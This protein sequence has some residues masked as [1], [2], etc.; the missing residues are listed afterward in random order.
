[1]LEFV[2][3]MTRDDEPR[4]DPALWRRLQRHLA[5]PRAPIDPSHYEW[6][7]V[8][9]G[10]RRH[11]LEDGARHGFRR[12]LVSIEPDGR[13]P[14]HGHDRAEDV[15]VLEGGLTLECENDGAYLAGSVFRSRAGHRHQG[16]ALPGARC[17]CHVVEYGEF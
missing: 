9:P 10:I 14:E 12:Y 5:A 13:I 4:P 1:M 11:L 3:G 6:T 17:V 16:R 15:L 7:E 8:A 2:T